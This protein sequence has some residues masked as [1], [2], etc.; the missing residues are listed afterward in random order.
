MIIC[1]TSNI[2]LIH[3]QDVEGYGKIDGITDWRITNIP[4]ITPGQTGIFS[5]FNSVTP[6]IP[7]IS[8][9]ETGTVGIGTIP[10]ISST[11]K[12]EIQGN[13]NI[14]GSYNINNRNAMNDT[15]NYI[16]SSS[17]A[18]VAR[19]NA[20]GAEG[21][22][23]VS[24]NATSNTILSIANNNYSSGT[25]FIAEF[26][27]VGNTAPTTHT[28]VTDTPTDRYM[29]FTTASVNHTFTI[30]AGGLNCDILMIGGG[31]G[32]Y[33]GGGGAGA[34]IVAINQTLPAGVCVV[35]V[36]AGVNYSQTAGADSYI[37]VA[38]LDR[39]RAKGGGTN[40][41]DDNGNGVSG[42]D[43]GCGGGA[44]RSLIV[45]YG[46]QPVQTNVVN[47]VIENTLP[48]IT[49]TYA[50]MGNPGGGNNGDSN[51]RGSGGGIGTAGVAGVG[52]NGLYQVTLTGASTP[53]NFRNYFA[54][55]STSFGVQDG[56][57]GNYYI[58][59]GGGANY[60]GGWQAGG[61]GGGNTNN[62]IAQANTGSGTGSI[63]S[64]GSG[65]IIIRYRSVPMV[66]GTPS[67]ELIRGKVGDTNTDYK[68]GNY[69]GD[70]KVMS[71]ISN[72]DTDRM[73]I[74]SSGNVGIGTT[75]PYSKLQLYDEEVNTTKLTIHNNNITDINNSIELSTPL[76]NVSG[77]I[78]GSTDKF[79]IFKTTGINYTFSI[80]FGGMV[81]DIL[82]IGGGG[83]SGGNGG[84]AG[85]G[86][87]IVAINQTLPAGSCVVVVGDG[88]V[89]FAGGY[90]SSISV[91][92][93]TIFNARGGGNG[94]GYGGNGGWG[95]SGGGG[96][97][98][99]GGVTNGGGAV[100]DNVVNGSFTGPTSTSTFV[101]LGNGGGRV[102]VDPGQAGGGGIGGGGGNCSYP[103]SHGGG[104]GGLNAVTINSISYNFKTWFANN[105]AFGDNNNGYIGGGGSG[106][107]GSGPA[108]T[109]NGGGSSGAGGSG[110]V[111]I[112]YRNIISK[113][114][115]IELIQGSANNNTNYKIGNYNGDFKV[116]SSISNANTDRM[117]IKSSGNYYYATSTGPHVFYTTDSNTERMRITN[118]G[119]VGIGTTNPG[120]ILQVGNSSRLRIS[121]DA[122]DYTRIGT[123]DVL[124]TTNTRILLF[125]NTSASYSGQIDYYAT[126]TGP[127]VFYTTDSNTERMR[128][129]NTGNVGIGVSPATKLHVAGDIFATGNITAYY[130]DER[131]KTKI[132]NI[133][134]PLEIINK[135]NGFYYTPNDLARKNGVTNTGIE[136]GLSAQEVQKVLP[137]IVKI[138]P[139]DSERN[140]DGVIV[141]KSGEN[142]L[143]MSYERL[144]PVF[145]EAIKELE[146]KYIEL[147][148]EITLIKE[149]LK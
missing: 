78:T 93:N 82:M 13:V 133:K 68:I 141:S 120:N 7:S 67:I 132:S 137:E 45:R 98:S 49:S 85:S 12:M 75:N 60:N 126:S 6:T 79:M 136:I 56:S 76:A 8:I 72:A 15:S 5:I 86:A 31:G 139:F 140:K 135:L 27:G 90:D 3:G 52:G 16:L 94:G 18:I 97:R 64:G 63:A 35:N 80:P 61:L 46:G 42:N 70:F 66:V 146:R 124:G 149:K 29:M 71:S 73:I 41:S 19:I 96:G 122:S 138:A 89:N 28:Q 130:S 128:I 51:S 22:M 84:G 117:I 111:M 109:G 92:G 102:T 4:S 32:G 144:V 125:G 87:C 118:T 116:M 59:G 134:D 25:P 83:G 91:T 148:R 77:N 54:N 99:S 110:I 30:P 37:Q 145:V 74:K 14:T 43:G 147:T 1:S 108:N 40:V 65:I 55:G 115:S 53:I 127:H 100:G 114:A 17:N 48:R 62:V 21:N 26:I 9:L 107:G 119:N 24:N 11:S 69:N 44:G 113:I 10:S 34:C 129:T 50:V 39:Y 123:N 57:T 23:T 112:R 142:Y 131:L 105:E 58:G 106:W 20:F 88:G 95:G 2:D 47:G 103:G 38:T 36:G 143:T 101:V 121:N 81:C 33:N 104:G